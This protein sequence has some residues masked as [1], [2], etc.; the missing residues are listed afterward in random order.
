MARKRL[1]CRAYT[2]DEKRCKRLMRSHNYRALCTQHD[3]M[4]TPGKFY[5]GVR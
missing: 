3:R 4:Q 2:L 1:R 5:K